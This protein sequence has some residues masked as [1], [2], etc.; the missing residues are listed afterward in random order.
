MQVKQLKSTLVLVPLMLTLCACTAEQSTKTVQ[1]STQ[2]YPQSS[3]SQLQET[4]ISHPSS[5][6]VV[7]AVNIG[8]K[9]VAL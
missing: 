7:W 4:P 9:Q 3:K 8:G 5:N 1:T 6:N 2:A